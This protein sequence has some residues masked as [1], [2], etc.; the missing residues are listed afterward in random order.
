MNDQEL[1]ER[2]KEAGDN[3]AKEILVNFPVEAQTAVLSAAM[4][5][6][7]R[8][9]QIAVENAAKDLEGTKEAYD[10]FLKGNK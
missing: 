6:M 7:D 4:K 1:N 5:T 3:M 8:H 10:A 9:Y 2:I